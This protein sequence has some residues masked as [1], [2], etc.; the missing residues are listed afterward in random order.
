MG[1][2]KWDVDEL[3]KEL[4]CSRRTVYRDLQTLSLAG[5]AWYIDP[6]TKSLRVRSGFRF[7]KLDDLC[8]MVGADSGTKSTDFLIATKELIRDTEQFLTKLRSLL[9]SLENLTLS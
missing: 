8:Q 7:S 2:G 9:S 6:A 3:A 4:E 5:V 1:P